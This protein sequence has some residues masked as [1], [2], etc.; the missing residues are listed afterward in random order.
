MHSFFFSLVRVAFAPAR[1]R[2]RS[3][4]TA[5]RLLTTSSRPRLRS[6][7][8][9]SSP[10]PVRV[11]AAAGVTF[12]LFLPR[13]RDATSGLRAWLSSVRRRRCRLCLQVRSPSPPS[14]S[15]IAAAA[16]RWL[17]TPASAIFSFSLL[18][19]ACGRRCPRLRARPSFAAVRRCP[20]PQ[21]AAVIVGDRLHRRLLEIELADEARVQRPPLKPKL[22]SSP[23]TAPP[24]SSSERLTG[25][26]SGGG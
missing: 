15:P 24:S 8:P 7:S 1:L 9:P 11:A 14:P 13:V 2:P 19:F 6:P 17:P 22:S 4:S 3:A 10:S 25:E 18:A 23:V 21:I 26:R 12:S 16:D 20:R 5:A